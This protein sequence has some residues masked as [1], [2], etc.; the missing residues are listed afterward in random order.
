[1]TI[2]ALVD[3]SITPLHRDDTPQHSMNVVIDSVYTY[4]PVVDD[5]ECLV[6]LITEQQVMQAL[7]SAGTVG[8][9][10]ADEPVSVAPETHYYNAARVMIDHDVDLLPVT[11][12][13]GE[14]QGVVSRADLFGEFAEMLGTARRGAILVL[15]IPPRD[16]AMGQ[17]LHVIEQ[18]D[19]KVHS[20]VTEEENRETLRITLK[21]NIRDATRTRHMLDHHG[22]SVVAAFNE[23]ASQEELQDRAREFMRYLEV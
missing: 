14:Y 11:G 8:D 18:N 15:E 2:Q 5:D 23:A 10:L 9:C 19:V 6:G 3:R 7:G 16:Y 17:L 22:Y 21:L 4:L 20:M 1:M 12:P 13:S